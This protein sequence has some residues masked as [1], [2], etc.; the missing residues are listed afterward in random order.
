[1]ITGTSEIE[2][3]ISSGCKTSFFIVHSK[4]DSENLA[5]M[6]ASFSKS[7]KNSSKLILYKNIIFHP[8]PFDIL[9]AFE[10][11]VSV[12]KLQLIIEKSNTEH[13]P[14]LQLP[15][16]TNLNLES[17]Q[18]KNLY[19]CLK[20]LRIANLCNIKVCNNLIKEKFDWNNSKHKLM[21]KTIW[22]KLKSVKTCDEKVVDWTE[23]GFQG[24]RISIISFKFLSYMINQI[25]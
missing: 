3:I 12:K 21:L 22:L 13:T 1:M 19:I 17:K 25:T 8:K 20:A 6:M 2:R 4:E 5:C 18:S 11:I 24:Q 7:I 10:H 15:E 16:A 9:E 23:L 14:L